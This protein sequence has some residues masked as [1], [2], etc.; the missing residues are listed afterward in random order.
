VSVGTSTISS[1]D[2]T[3]AVL[4]TR[5]TPG[6]VDGSTAK[7]TVNVSLAPLGR[8]PAV[9]VGSRKV[10]EPPGEIEST[11]TPAGNVSSWFRATPDASDGP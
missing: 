5:S 1:T 4:L 6:V 11:L 2:V 9:E 8:L 10:V 3:E 7:T